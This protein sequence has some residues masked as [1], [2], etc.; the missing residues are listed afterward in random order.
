MIVNALYN[1]AWTLV[2]LL[3][4][5]NTHELFTRTCFLLR[6]TARDIPVSDYV[7]QGLKAL[8]WSLKQ[9]IPQTALPYLDPAGATPVD[10]T[11][12]PMALALPQHREIQEILSDDDSDSSNMGEELGSLLSKWSAMSVK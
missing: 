12:V 5:P 8:A 11:D 2:C 4:D 1:T 3:Y 7:L 10:T 9:R 6:W